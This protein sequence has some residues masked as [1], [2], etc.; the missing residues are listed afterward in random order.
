MVSLPAGKRIY[1]WYM[2]CDWTNLDRSFRG[3]PW[4]FSSRFSLHPV[5]GEIL[6]WKQQ[7]QGRQHFSIGT[8]KKHCG[9]CNQSTSSHTRGKS[10]LLED[11]W[12][13]Q[14]S[15]GRGV[16]SE[17][18]QTDSHMGKKGTCQESPC[19]DFIVQ[20][21]SMFLEV[22]KQESLF[23]GLGLIKQTAKLLI[24]YIYFNCKLYE[25]MIVFASR[26][27]WYKYIQ[28]IR[29]NCDKLRQAVCP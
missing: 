18:D 10:R 25:M 29:I 17:A 12:R 4:F 19:V 22:S 14:H 16:P 3:K 15:R 8:K 2:N 11:M 7:T 6:A 21:P 13:F 5:L 28:L 9:D 1:W 20:R 27:T 26:A 24:N 23:R